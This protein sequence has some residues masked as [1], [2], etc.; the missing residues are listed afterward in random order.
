MFAMFLGVKGGFA[1]DGKSYSLDVSVGQIVSGGGL[2]IQLDKLKLLDD[3]PDKY[4]ISVKDDSDIIADHVVLV[5]YDTLSFKTRCGTVTI[6]ADRKSMFHH[7]VLT[8]NWSYF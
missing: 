8:V 4:T 3:D 6:G 1:C 5:Q 7:S 2:A